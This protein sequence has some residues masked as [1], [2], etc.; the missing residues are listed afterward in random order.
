MVLLTGV[1]S[2][3]YL[4]VIDKGYR[5]ICIVVFPKT[6]KIWAPLR[7]VA[8]NDGMPLFNPLKFEY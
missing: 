4:I 6:Q 3:C 7:G 5:L 2:V 8:Q 1:N